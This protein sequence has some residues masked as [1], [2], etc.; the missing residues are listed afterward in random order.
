VRSAYTAKGWDASDMTRTSEQCVRE[1]RT[2]EGSGAGGLHKLAM[3]PAATAAA[4]ALKPGA[5]VTDVGSVKVSVGDA[6]RAAVPASLLTTRT[7]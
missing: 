3:G 7:L 6:L 4:T 2:A 1:G 5:T